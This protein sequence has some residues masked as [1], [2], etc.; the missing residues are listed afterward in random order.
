MPDAFVHQLPIRVYYEDTDF[1]GVVYHASFLRFM[2]RG[3]TEFLRAAGVHQRNLHAGPGGFYFVVRRMTIDWLKPGRMDD[4]L[5][6]ETSVPEMKAASLVM[7]QAVRRGG[8][9]LATADVTVVGI[10]DDR[11]ARLPEDLRLALVA[12]AAGE[13]S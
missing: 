11:V 4:E 13:A 1:S 12:F 10:R 9:T 5:V 6:V 7:R 3:R 2:E 8:E